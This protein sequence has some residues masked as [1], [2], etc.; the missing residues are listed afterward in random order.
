MSSYSSGCLSFS[1][2]VETQT[3]F[4]TLDFMG[5]AEY[6][7]GTDGTVWTKKRSTKW[8]ELRASK[9]KDGHLRVTLFANAQRHQFFVHQLVLRAFVGPPG[10]GEQCRHFFE[11]DP[12]NNKLENLRYGSSKQN[13]H[14]S[15]RHD[16]WGRGDRNGRA[17]ITDEHAREIHR[18]YLTGAYTQDQLAAMFNVRRHVVEGLLW[19][20]TWKHLKLDPVPRCIGRNNQRKSMSSLV[21]ERHPGAKLTNEQVKEMRRLYAAANHSQRQLARI[22]HVDFRIVHQIVKGKS[23]K[24]AAGCSGIPA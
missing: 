17:L 13:K 23:Y 14:D 6:R 4:R 15:I 8:K 3:V 2:D 20:S 21:G 5:Y 24:G 22:F 12:A 9:C 19:G 18:L 11:P 1:Y 10:S 16:T 7:A